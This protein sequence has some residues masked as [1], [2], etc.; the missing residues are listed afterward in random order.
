[1]KQ[2]KPERLRFQRGEKAENASVSCVA[3]FVPRGTEGSWCGQE[4]EDP[5]SV[6]G[7]ELGND[8]QGRPSVVL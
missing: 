8:K 2:Q 4:V 7:R 6:L 5:G 3:A 1:M